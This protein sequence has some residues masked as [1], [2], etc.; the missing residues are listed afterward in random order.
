MSDVSKVADW[1]TPSFYFSTETSKKQAE[2]VWTSFVGAPE[3]IP[4]I[5]SKAY[6][7]QPNAK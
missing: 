3:Y 6:S 7:N 2:A 4:G 1:E 5:Y